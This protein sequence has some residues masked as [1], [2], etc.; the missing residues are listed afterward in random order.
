MTHYSPFTVGF[1]SVGVLYSP[2]GLARSG[3]DW[4]S[5]S[6]SVLVRVVGGRL[7]PGLVVLTGRLD[8]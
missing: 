1:R 3:F 4:W 2:V 7:G 6:V 5:T 8:T